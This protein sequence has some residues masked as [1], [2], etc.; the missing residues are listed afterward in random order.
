MIEI[1]LGL[2]IGVGVT[3]LVQRRLP[4]PPLFRSVYAD[5]ADHDLAET[6]RHATRRYRE[7]LASGS[8]TLAAMESKIIRDVEKEQAYRLDARTPTQGPTGTAGDSSA[9]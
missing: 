7:H 5:A 3:L 8:P 2:L 9:N 1:I 6:H 4:V